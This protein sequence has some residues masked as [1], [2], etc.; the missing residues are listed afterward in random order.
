MRTWAPIYPGDILDP[1]R[2]SVREGARNQHS[3][4]LATTNLARLAL[5]HGHGSDRRNPRMSPG[6]QSVPGAGASKCTTQ[7]GSRM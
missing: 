3:H 1:R 6:G 2:I 5:N 4:H 7:A